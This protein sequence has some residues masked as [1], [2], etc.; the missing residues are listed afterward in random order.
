[1]KKLALALILFA[2][3]TN[4][5]SIGCKDVGDI[6]ESLM[7]ARQANVPISKIIE[8]VPKLK[9]LTLEAYKYPAYSSDKYRTKAIKEFRNRVEI[10]CYKKGG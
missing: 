1:M 6:A 10:A 2:N 9:G 3:V 4:A 8:K 5:A 7:K